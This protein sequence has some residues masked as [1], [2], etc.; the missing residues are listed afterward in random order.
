M[1]IKKE[2]QWQANVSGFFFI[3]VF[4]FLLQQRAAVLKKNI[5]TVKPTVCYHFAF[6]YNVCKH[7]HTFA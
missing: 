5:Y 7:S 4:M 3:F 1:E 6:N 2:A